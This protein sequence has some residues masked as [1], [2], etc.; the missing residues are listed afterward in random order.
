MGHCLS[1]NARNNGARHKTTSRGGDIRS[2]GGGVPYGGG[3]MSGRNNTKNRVESIQETKTATFGGL[4]V[5]YAYLSQ[6]GYYPDGK[7]HVIYI[8]YMRDCTTM[9]YTLLYDV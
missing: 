4:Q 8:M 5:R 2:S 1:S 6:R 7:C 3:P 9:T